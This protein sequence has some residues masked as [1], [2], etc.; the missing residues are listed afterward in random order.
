MGYR[1]TESHLREVIKEQ[2]EGLGP[3]HPATLSGMERLAQILYIRGEH[4]EAKNYAQEVFQERV[5]VLGTGHPNTAF[6]RELLTEIFHASSIENPMAIAATSYQEILSIPQTPSLVPLPPPKHPDL[7]LPN[8]QKGIKPLYSRRTI[9]I[10]TPSSR[11]LSVEKPPPSS[12]PLT[13]GV[14]DLSEK[15]PTEEDSRG[16]GPYTNREILEVSSTLK[17]Q[18]PRWS[19]L[20]RTYVILDRIG[21]LDVFDN[22]IEAGFTDYM[23]PVAEALIP[24]CLP[25]SKRSDF[26]ETQDLIMN[27]STDLEEGNHCYF[28]GDEGPQLKTEQALGAGAFGRVDKVRSLTS[29]EVYARKR[30][31]RSTK[32]TTKTAEQMK[33]LVAEIEVLK[34]LDHHHVVKFVGSYTDPKYVGFI[35]SPVAEMDLKAY[36][37][38][39]DEHREKLRSFFGCLA[40]A[41]EYLHRQ[42]VRHK[43]I[44]PSNILVKDGKVFLTD[45]GLSLDFK[46]TDESTTNSVVKGWTPRYGAPEVAM[47]KPR[48][49]S[50]D[51]WSLGV[52]FLEMVVVLKG[53]SIE[54]MNEFFEANGKRNR[55][56]FANRHAVPRLIAELERTGSSSDNI[57]L[58][59]IQRM[60]KV[61]PALRPT[62]RR[63]VA[64]IATAGAT[65][66]GTTAFF[67]GE[68]CVS[69]DENSGSDEEDDWE[70]A[71]IASDD[72]D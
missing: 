18:N 50:S 43:D 51:I 61:K 11:R 42:K 41:L 53:R 1:E 46:D 12:S 32:L 39:A 56:A 62:A 30:V 2:S 58:Q 19:S 28:K 35:M 69:L 17:S 15:N 57:I 9:S 34:C 26:M 71:D 44:K 7:E 64:S 33:Q 22:F 49:T 4:E 68:C 5:R 37:R 52:V 54:Y 70:R 20:P 10:A 72:E 24:R 13:E 48:N 67:C 8:P 45:F 14:G 40:Q 29:H 55:Y 63:L 38:Q 31:R 21:C 47:F 65:E 3:G 16:W 60:L 6:I 66:E 27:Y 36:L 25:R 23:F 59:W